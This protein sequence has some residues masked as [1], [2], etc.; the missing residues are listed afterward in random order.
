MYYYMRSLLTSNA[1]QSAKESL[2][3]LFDDIRRKYE[4]TEMKQSPMHCGMGNQKK[5]KQMRREVWI[6]PDG[7]R[8]LHRTDLK[9]KLK[10]KSTIAETNRYDELPPEELLPRIMSLYLFLVGKLFT[11]TE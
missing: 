10:N 9:N 8:R 6:Y 3:D 2:L 5:S 11:A 1:I 7:I 4:E